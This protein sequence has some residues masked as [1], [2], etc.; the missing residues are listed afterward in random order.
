MTLIIILLALFA[1]RPTSS[2]QFQ[3]GSLT[4]DC[5]Y[6]CQSCSD[7]GPSSCTSCYANYILN[8]NSCIPCADNCL[9]C[10]A[11]TGLCQT[12]ASQFYLSQSTWTCRP[13][14]VG[15]QT[16]TFSAIQQ[17]LPGY[18]LVNSI[19][20]FCISN[21]YTCSDAYSCQVCNSGYYLTPELTCS[22]CLIAHC[23]SCDSSGTCSL[24]SNNRYGS[25]CDQLCPEFCQICDSSACY[26][27]NSG[28]YQSSTGSC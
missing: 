22:A 25:N 19:C 24:C 23:S 18:Y 5:F 10:V 27:C 9:S 26:Q 20:F 14:P 7:V 11:A 3:N 12:C 1:F 13:C 8:N 28:Y 4:Y 2:S 21:C 16:C 6:R 15:A 17:C